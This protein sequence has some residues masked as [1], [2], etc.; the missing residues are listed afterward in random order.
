[1]INIFKTKEKKEALLDLSIIKNKIYAFQEMQKKKESRAIEYGKS[2]DKLPDLFCEYAGFGQSIDSGYGMD[3][4]SYKTAWMSDL[5]DDGSFNFHFNYLL[6][7]E[8][9][10]T[11]SCEMMCTKDKDD[12]L[13]KVVNCDYHRIDNESDL[14]ILLQDII[15]LSE[16]K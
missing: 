15:N 4:S 2:L 1:M 3:S 9:V 7:S 5:L 6:E 11:F 14:V 16:L 13:V 12:F 10:I 8:E